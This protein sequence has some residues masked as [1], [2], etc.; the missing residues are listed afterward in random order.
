MVGQ[1]SAVINTFNEEKNI[2]RAIKSVA[3][4]D[5]IIVCDMYSN[6][7]TASLARK[8]GAKVV[9][10]KRTD[11]VEPA[12]NYALSKATGDWILILD[13]D[14]DIPETLA[15]RLQEIVNKTQQIEAVEIP[16]KNIIFGKWMKYTGWW[17]D[18]QIRFFQKGTVVWQDAIHSKPKLNGLVL[19]LEA[20]EQWAITHKNY[21]SIDQFIERMNRYSNFEAEQLQKKG[22]KFGWQDVLEKPLNEFLSRVFDEREMVIFYNI[23]SG[24]RFLNKDMEKA[25]RKV[26]R[27]DMKAALGYEDVNVNRQEFELGEKTTAALEKVAKTFKK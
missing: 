8:L 25:F 19:T 15:K 7:K 4:A 21:Q 1:I 20:K 17:P 6:D 13:A 14:E 16:R 5:E 10:H 26:A 23:A 11:F 24:P 22:Y 18:Y 2:Q 9:F 3:W 12:R 27:S